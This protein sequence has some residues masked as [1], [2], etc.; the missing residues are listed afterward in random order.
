VLFLVL[1][2]S[3]TVSRCRHDISSPS[4]MNNVALLPARRL[5]NAFAT[6]QVKRSFHGSG[7]LLSDQ[8]SSKATSAQ[9]E[10]NRKSSDDASGK[11]QKKTQ[12]Q[13]DAELQAAME[14]HAGDGGMSGAELEGG[15]AVSMKRG[16]R[17]NMFRYI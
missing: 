6:L 15:K 8:R 14:G 9:K 12:A 13:L 3:F 16:V 7:Q 5:G 10:E 17:D 2:T 4:N 11:K 1:A